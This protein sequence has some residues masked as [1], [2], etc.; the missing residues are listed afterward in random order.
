MRICYW[1]IESSSLDAEYGQMLCAVI[2]EHMSESPEEPKIH[3]FTLGNFQHERWNDTSLAVAVRD[4]LEEYDL[5]ISYN[6][7]RFDL[8]FLNTRLIEAGER[9]TVLRRHKDLL[10]TMRG[11][12]RLG[13]NRLARVTQFFFG[14]TQKTSIDP[15]TW[16]QAICGKRAAYDYIIDHCQRDVTELARVWHKVKDVSGV[17]K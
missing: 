15:K 6:G 5:V 13:S 12:F 11:R 17:L 16:R 2:G 10:Y 4:A 9:G 8:P 14:E 1:D 7:A 3:T